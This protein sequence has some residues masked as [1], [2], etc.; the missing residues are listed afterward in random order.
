MK[1][2]IQEV[3]NPKLTDVESKTL[4]IQVAYGILN[5]ADFELVV[6]EFGLLTVF[7]D[8]GEI[9]FNFKEYHSVLSG[10]PR[11]ELIKPKEYNLPPYEFIEY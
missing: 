6:D 8:K 9:A 4:A 7:S 5:A 11:S 3:M 1:T 10:D 2:M